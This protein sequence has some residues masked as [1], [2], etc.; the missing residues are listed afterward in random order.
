MKDSLLPLNGLLSL[1][2]LRIHLLDS[3]Q[4]SFGEILLKSFSHF[5]LMLV[6]KGIYQSRK[7][8]IVRETGESW[9]EIANGG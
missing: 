9:G 1:V 5:F 3:F 6:I 8:G 7:Q 2:V 4:V